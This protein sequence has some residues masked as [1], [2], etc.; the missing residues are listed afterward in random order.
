[1]TA[2]IGVAIVT[3]MAIAVTIVIEKVLERPSSYRTS[4][5]VE[6]A[7]GD[8]EEIAPVL[9][10]ELVGLGVQRVGRRIPH[11][12]VDAH[13]VTAAAAV[14]VAHADEEHGAAAHAGDD[15]APGEWVR[16]ARRGAAGV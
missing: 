5:R 8:D 9:V 2:M 1:M 14:A 3:V 11:D 15:D 4:R 16:E 13:D 7:V 6:D 12:L 10:E